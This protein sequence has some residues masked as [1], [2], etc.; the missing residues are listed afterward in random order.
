MFL[1]QPLVSQAAR[2][3]SSLFS[4]CVSGDVRGLNRHGGKE[5]G[6]MGSSRQCARLW[7]APSTAHLQGAGRG[8]EGG[9][10]GVSF[11]D[12]H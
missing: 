3:R 8:V 5:E 6:P 10:G 12:I 1:G 11:R 7:L 4:V 2:G 9:G